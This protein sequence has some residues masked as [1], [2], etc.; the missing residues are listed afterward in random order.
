M[1]LLINTLKRCLQGVQPAIGI[2]AMLL[3]IKNMI[4]MILKGGKT[5]RFFSLTKVK[6]RLGFILEKYSV[7]YME[8]WSGERE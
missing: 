4:L 3:T 2:E 1:N 8:Q 7:I 5:I 6:S